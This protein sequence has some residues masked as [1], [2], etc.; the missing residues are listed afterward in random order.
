MNYS[1]S[2]YLCLNVQTNSANMPFNPVTKYRKADFVCID[3]PEAKIASGDKY[4]SKTQMYIKILKKSKFKNLVF[5]EGKNG[6]WYFR[7][8]KALNAPAFNNSV[9]DTMGAGD[10]FFSISSLIMQIN[11]NVELACFL[12]NIAGALKTSILGHSKF[13]NRQDFYKYLKTLVVK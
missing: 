8:N 3:I 11:K 1:H 7:N 6:S 13:I 5:T 4:L 2:K 9:I 10:A 12:G